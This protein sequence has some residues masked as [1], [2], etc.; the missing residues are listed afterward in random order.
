MNAKMVITVPMNKVP[1]EITR[2]LENIVEQLKQ[3]TEK[4]GNCSYNNDHN[5]VIEEIDDIRKNLSLVDLNLEDCYT[6]LLGYVKYQTDMRIK[7]VEENKQESTDA[8]NNK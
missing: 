3:I 7:K 2:I 4:T 1:D 8:S 6:V 5:L